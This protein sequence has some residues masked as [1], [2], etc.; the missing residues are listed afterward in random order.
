MSNCNQGELAIRCVT[1]CLHKVDNDATVFNRPTPDGPSVPPVN[2]R[3]DTHTAPLSAVVLKVSKL[4]HYFVVQKYAYIESS[5]S[6]R[7]NKDENSFY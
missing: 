7:G 1:N 5:W 6:L 2:A 3:P 4:Q